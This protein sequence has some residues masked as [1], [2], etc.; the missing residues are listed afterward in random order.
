MDFVC[1]FIKYL[2]IT[3]I[4][5]NSELLVGEAVAVNAE[6]KGDLGTLDLL[7]G[8]AVAVELTL[9]ERGSRYPRS[10]C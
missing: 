3:R 4:I 6:R 2:S 7:V 9:S 10:P 5:A 1:A 8:E